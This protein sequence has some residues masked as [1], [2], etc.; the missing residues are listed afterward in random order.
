MTLF[1]KNWPAGG[2]TKTG[3][4]LTA[5]LIWLAI[6]SFIRWANRLTGSGPIGWAPCV[7]ID[8]AHS[9]NRFVYQRLTQIKD[10]H[11]HIDNR[12]RHTEAKYVTVT[13]ILCPRQ[14]NFRTHEYDIHR[15]TGTKLQLPDKLECKSNEWLWIFLT[16]HF[17]VDVVIAFLRWLLL[18]L[19]LWLGRFCGRFRGR[20]RFPID[21]I[22]R[23]QPHGLLVSLDGLNHLLKPIPSGVRMIPLQAPLLLCMSLSVH[24]R[25]P[26][27]NSSRHRPNF[28]DVRP[29]L[30]VVLCC[31]WQNMFCPQNSKP[32]GS[33]K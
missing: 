14:A 12:S 15:A 32:N 4:S 13:S 28:T 6:Y 16:C 21:A 1:D 5:E 23:V 26:L 30:C 20:F 11:A 3:I 33:K 18:A 22:F 31:D 8:A 7:L 10:V 24:T 29:E 25:C 9:Q 17:I 19:G 2:R 27:Q